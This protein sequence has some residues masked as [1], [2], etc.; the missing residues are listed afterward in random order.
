MKQMVMGHGNV[1]FSTYEKLKH[2]DESKYYELEYC[3]VFKFINI[4]YAEGLKSGKM[5]STNKQQS[6]STLNMELETC[7]RYKTKL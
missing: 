2:N 3:A 6:E 5:L 1:N 7:K 4:I